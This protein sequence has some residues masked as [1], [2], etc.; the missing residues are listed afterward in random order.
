MSLLRPC[1]LLTLSICLLRCAPL[2]AADLERQRA[3]LTSKYA[4]EL[5][6]LAESCRAEQLD[7]AAEELSAW[8]PQRSPDQLTLFVLPRGSESP[9][10]ADKTSGEPWR[11]KWQ[12]LRDAQA[13]ALWSLARQALAEHQPSLAYQLVTE[14][15]RE[16]PDHKAARRMLGYARFRDAWHTPFEVRQLN[17]GR[18]WHPTFGWLAKGHAERY[19]RGER[20]Y[21][22][23]WMTADAEAALRQDVRRGWRVESEHY[24]VTTNHSLEAGVRLSQRLETLYSLWQQTFVG[25]LTSEGE[26]LRRFDGRAT[27]REPRQHNVVY[28]RNRQ[29][30]NDALRKLQPRIEITIG[31]YLSEPRTAYFFAGDEAATVDDDAATLYHEATHQLFHESRSVAPQIGQQ[32]NFWAIE[33]IACYMETLAE[34]AEGA[35]YTLGGSNSGRVP[36]A[37]HRLL[38]DNF[39][40]PLAELVAMGMQ[41]LQADPRIQPLYSQSAG[42][43]DFFMHA[44]GGKYREPF[45]NYLSA[46]YQGR[47]DADTLSKLTGASYPQLDQQ[48]R[49]FLSQAAAPASADEAAAR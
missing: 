14:T 28:Y 23:R 47:A 19:E 33:G 13:E 18:K 10:P 41:S 6:K 27:R 15:V 31:I 9:A 49:A 17:A 26:L 11:A 39:Y 46:I 16:N 34:H 45:V 35:Y 48:Y 32:A 42:L 5:Q 25:Y 36:A 1:L 29:Q 30:Y 37:R 43:L 3:E 12:A 8:L 21:Q 7:D 38:T 44:H 20:Y 4:A 22:G 2:S 24:V 40:V